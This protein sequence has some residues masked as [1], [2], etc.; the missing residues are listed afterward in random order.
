[1]SVVVA[2]DRSRSL[3]L[4]LLAVLVSVILLSPE[5]SAAFPSAT[6]TAGMRP[7]EVAVQVQFQIPFYSP[8]PKPYVKKKRK[9][10]VKRRRPRP[11]VVK[12]QCAHPWTYS[13][14]LRKCIC[15]REGYGVADGKCQKLAEI[16]ATNGTW[17]REQNRCVCD[18]GFVLKG[19]RCLE[20][21]V[22]NAPAKQPS[23]AHC[24]WPM[25]PDGDGGACTCAP[26]YK[27]A[28]GACVH[29]S[30]D[31]ADTARQARTDGLLTTE[32]ALVQQCLKEAG[33]LRGAVA[34]RMTKRAWTAYWFFKQDYKVGSTPQGILHPGAQQSLF[35]LCPLAAR[36]VK[37]VR[38][39]AVGTDRPGTPDE[40][41]SRADEG[42]QPLS[43]PSEIKKVYAKPEAQCLPAD[44]HRL[45]V[46]S[47]GNRSGLKRCTET[48]I[49]VP[50]GLSAR[51]VAALESRGVAWCQACLEISSQLPL[52]DVLRIER[53]ADVQICTRPPKR[54]RRWQSADG[55][56]HVAYTKVRQLYRTLPT[57]TDHADDIA[58]VIGNKNYQGGWPSNDSA[59][60]N[61]G[62][63]YALLTEH[64]GF[65]Q[66]NIIDLRDAT[67]SDFTRVFGAGGDEP[68]GELHERLQNT[69][70]ANVL[71]YYAGHG[72]T[73]LDQTR[74]YLL[75]VDAVQHREDRSAYPMSRLYANLAALG[76]KSVMVFLEAGFGRDHSDFVF[77]PNAPEF[78][79][80]S[81]P[82]TSID[83][84]TVITSA[85]KDQRTLDDVE[86][87]IGLFTRYLIEG[88]AG[89]ADLEP[90]GNNDLKIDVVELYAYVARMVDLAARKS[91]GMLQRPVLKGT[92]NRAIS[93]VQAQIQ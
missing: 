13:Q 32:T 35:E 10:R 29:E 20:P 14:G 67:L 71:I 6:T 36:A 40:I 30:E 61:A 22:A 15:V 25:I 51:E 27:E 89:S 39:A 78:G 77:A 82:T 18:G 43:S 41:D 72:T 52:S 19:D 33:Y 21:H 63:M 28:A 49:A 50:K 23:G 83:G 92:G 75:P 56:P 65:D 84:L 79:V 91:Y 31:A 80:H 16:C 68:G 47:Y 57:A 46:R 55:A 69:A 53:G 90:I 93:T 59:H 66:E 24:I 44:L 11:R 76:A 12:P 2:S 42:P 7:A 26:G 74:S 87:G 37:G 73:S 5:R 9:R 62:A 1:M 4:I 38:V 54:L 45:I 64:L 60:N 86:F 85:Q 8:P 58:V 48:C 70:A 3:P 17:S 81:L 34:A 88:L